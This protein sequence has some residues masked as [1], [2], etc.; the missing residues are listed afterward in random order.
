MANLARQIARGV[1]EID[2]MQARLRTVPPVAPVTET[3]T[4][5]VPDEF[6]PWNTRVIPPATTEGDAQ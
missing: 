6:D 1:G 3:A 4:P 2:G 5:P